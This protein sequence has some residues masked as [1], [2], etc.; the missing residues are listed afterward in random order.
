[1]SR[2]T[3]SG[4][5][6]KIAIAW[7]VEIDGPSSHVVGVSA[8]GTS[9]P[10]C[11]PALCTVMG[12]TGPSTRRSAV[13]DTAATCAADDHW[14]KFVDD[15]THNDTLSSAA[16]WLIARPLS[17]LLLLLIG[18]V[19][20]WLVC[21]FIDRLTRRAASSTVPSF[22]GQGKVRQIIVEATNPVAAERRQQRAETMGSLLKSIA[23]A[24][25]ATVVLFMVVDQ[26]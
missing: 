9:I 13:A 19:V 23:T 25:I 20:R 24:V 22:L 14:C 6:T 12:A 26:L 5:P 17:I 18:Y 4:M 21:R 11:G 10:Y 7:S 16:D 3:N 2:I 15:V 1:M 8:R